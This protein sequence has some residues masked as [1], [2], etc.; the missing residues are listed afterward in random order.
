MRVLPVLLVL[1]A[2]AHADATR[3]STLLKREGSLL[4][5]LELDVTA[6]MQYEASL[7]RLSHERKVLDYEI[8]ETS[9]RLSALAKRIE[10]RRAQLRGRLVA[11]YKLSQ[12]GYARLLV[13]GS[14]RDDTLVGAAAASR[15]IERDL[16]ELAMH[17]R[18]LH[19][20]GQLRRRLQAKQADQIAL[21]DQERAKRDEIKRRRQVNRQALYRVRRS[22]KAKQ[23]LREELSAAERGLLRRVARLR[24]SVMRAAGLR[25]RKGVL[26][27]PVRGA[28]VGRPGKAVERASRIFLTRRGLTF[29]CGRRASV[30]AIYPG[31]VRVSEQIP[32]YGRIVLIDHGQGYYSL[33]G[34][35]SQ[36][37]VEVGQR[38]GTGTRIGTAGVDPLSGRPALYFELRRHQQAIDPRPWLRGA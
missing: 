12:G 1:L 35:L 6:L 3:L 27:R 20:L 17:K 7:A 38:V 18:D 15:L 11:M 36:T 16:T 37:E 34:F 19:R 23:K 8:S 22:R 26:P 24:G 30:R 33:A 31:V 9:R 21:H 10:D 2:T 4:A 28:I 5:G 13:D 29:S 25:S 14:N 32:G